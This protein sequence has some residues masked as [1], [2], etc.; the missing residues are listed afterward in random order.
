[1]Q[2]NEKEYE[3]TVPG[4]VALAPDGMEHALDVGCAGGALGSYLKSQKKYKTVV[5]IEYSKSSAAKARLLLDEVYVGD[6][7]II[8]LPTK[9]RNYFDLIVYTNVLEH[10]YDP[11]SVI[12]RH[13]A[14]LREGGYMLASIPNMRNLFILLHLLIGRFDYTELGLLDKTHI[15]FFTADT[16]LEM[17][18]N[19]GFILDRMART[20]CDAKW[21]ADLNDRPIQPAI[22]EFY[23]KIYQ[24]HMRGEDCS[25]DLQQCFGL[26][27]FTIEATVEFLTSQYHLLLRKPVTG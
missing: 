18:I 1:M 9:Y 23:D 15:R 22:L 24:K 8:D 21:H 26:F 25:S 3:F 19:A 13:K 7:C 20:I 6:A 2:A 5:G 10:L 4:A 17:F 11:W 12:T 27:S 14:Y 16:A